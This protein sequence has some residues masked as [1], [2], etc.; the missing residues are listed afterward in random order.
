MRMHGGPAGGRRSVSV[1]GKRDVSRERAAAGPA[2][3]PPNSR[4]WTPATHRPRGRPSTPAGLPAVRPQR[5]RVV[6]ALDATA[7]GPDGQR[8]PTIYQVDGNR[9]S[10]T[11]D[12]ELSTLAVERGQRV[13]GLVTARE[14]GDARQM[15]LDLHRKSCW[16]SRSAAAATVDKTTRVPSGPPGSSARPRRSSDSPSPARS[17]RIVVSAIVSRGTT[18]PGRDRLADVHGRIGFRADGFLGRRRCRRRRR[19]RVGGVGS[20]NIPEP[21][22]IAA[23]RPF[24]RC[25]CR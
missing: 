5:R 13:L 12:Q 18:V 7:G 8:P 16:R 20:V 4:T 10:M 23:G 3:P 9:S 22:A 17:G 1:I 24:G 25:G 6:V 14:R 19:S 2:A 21:Y 11:S 15:L